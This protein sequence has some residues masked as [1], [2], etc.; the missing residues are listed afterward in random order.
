MTGAGNFSRKINTHTKLRSI[1]SRN[2]DVNH[3]S[4]GR[5]VEPPDEFFKELHNY[6]QTHEFH[7]INYDPIDEMY[8]DEEGY[9]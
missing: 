1:F 5:E 2:S 3:I 6:F 4:H 7:G 9:I 8:K